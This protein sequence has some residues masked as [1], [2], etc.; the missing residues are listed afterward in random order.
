MNDFSYLNKRIFALTC[1]ID[2]YRKVRFNGITL[3]SFGALFAPINLIKEVTG[4]EKII[5][6]ICSLSKKTGGTVIVGCELT[7]GSNRKLSSVVAHAGTLC[8]ISD[9]CTA[10]AP[11]VASSSVKVY[12]GGDFSFALLVGNDVKSRLV[13]KKTA[14]RCDIIIANCHEN[15]TDDE[16]LVRV[17]SDET[18][19]PILYHSPSLTF[20]HT[21]NLN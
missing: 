16:R 21:P 11:F 4:E 8:D 6:S 17:L 15:D 7:L 13:V 19:T 3:F 10:V 14:P 12:S 5:S 2:E 9:S 18:D 20:F 1:P